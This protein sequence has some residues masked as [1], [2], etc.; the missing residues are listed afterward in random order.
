M[1]VCFWYLASSQFEDA[2][3]HFG[4]EVSVALFGSVASIKLSR[5][6]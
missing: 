3:A 6:I 2:A 1:K 4:I 5:S